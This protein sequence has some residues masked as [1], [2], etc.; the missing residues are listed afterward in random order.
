MASVQSPFSV[1]DGVHVLGQRLSAPGVTGAPG[2]PRARRPNWRGVLARRLPGLA[3]IALFLSLWEAAP[4]LGWVEST[5]LPPFSEVLHCAVDMARNGQLTAHI[6]GSLYRSLLGFS[7]AIVIGVP[8]GLFI[9]WFRS[10]SNAIHPLLE[11][12]RCTPALALLPVFVLLLGIGESSKIALVLYSCSWPILLNTTSAVRNVDPLLIKSARTLGLSTSRLLWHVVLPA[13][14]PTIF[15]GF[16]LAGAI[17]LVALVAAEML[18]AKAG[19]GYLIQY[20]QYNFQIPQM[21][22]G[23]LAIGLLGMIFTQT[24]VAIERRFTAWQP[25]AETGDANH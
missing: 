5:F 13:A 17:S 4:R 1:A 23:I 14:V 9:G 16:R 10:L 7:L 24:L 22:A 2:T 19:L 11:W 8:V 15:V 6:R 25:P 18:G 21:Y 12:F 20:S 3:V